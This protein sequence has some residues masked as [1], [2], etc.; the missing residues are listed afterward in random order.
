M[1]YSKT[2]IL[3]K[4]NKLMRGLSE[5]INLSRRLAIWRLGRTKLNCS[6]QNS[7]ICILLVLKSFTRNRFATISF[8][9][10]Q[11]LP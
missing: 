10:I 1:V 7:I 9:F 2:Y 3:R 11:P 6:R 8:L 5:L 4:V